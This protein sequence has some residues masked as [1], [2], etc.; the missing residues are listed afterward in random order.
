MLS[1]DTDQRSQVVFW[2]IPPTLLILTGSL[3]IPLLFPNI[4]D[5]CF[6]AMR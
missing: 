1:L 6:W 4:V 5:I 2:R 3:L